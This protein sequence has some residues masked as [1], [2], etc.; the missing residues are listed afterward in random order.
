MVKKKGEIVKENHCKSSL[1]KKS[2]MRLEAI[3]RLFS[4]RFFCLF[5]KTLN[6][7][8]RRAVGEYDW[9]SFNTDLEQTKWKPPG[10]ASISSEFRAHFAAFHRRIVAAFHRRKTSDVDQLP[11]Q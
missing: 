7:L 9:Q 11:V 8:W 1:E 10:E 2:K 4:T 3:F 6:D 5:L